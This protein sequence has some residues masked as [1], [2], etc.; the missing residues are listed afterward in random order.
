MCRLIR[1]FI[2]RIWH[3]QVSHDVALT[4]LIISPVPT[5]RVGMC[6]SAVCVCC[7]TVLSCCGNIFLTSI[8][9]VYFCFFLSVA[10][11]VSTRLRTAT[12][13]CVYSGDVRAWISSSL[14]SLPSKTT[15]LSH[16]MMKPTKWLCAQRRLRSAWTSAQS[17]QSLC[18]SFSKDP[19]FLQMWIARTDQTGQI[20]VIAGC[21]C[22]FVGFVMRQL[23]SLTGMHNKFKFN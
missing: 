3:K 10:F 21:T 15:K 13:W 11:S 20:W 1:T 17:D 6:L 9:V 14:S 22:H 16:L 8:F 23:K 12:A 18:W 2:V 19:S 5:C 7:D 4:Y